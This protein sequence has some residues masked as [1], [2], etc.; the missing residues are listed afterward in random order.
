MHLACGKKYMYAH[1]SETFIQLTHVCACA[2]VRALRAT[3]TASYK[4]HNTHPFPFI[5]TARAHAYN[6]M[7][8][9]Q[10]K[11]FSPASTT[12]AHQSY[13]IFDTRCRLNKMEAI[14]Q[15]PQNLLVFFSFF[16]LSSCNRLYDK[17]LV[18]LPGHTFSCTSTWVLIYFGVVIRCR[19]HFKLGLHIMRGKR[20]FYSLWYCADSYGHSLLKI[21]GQSKINQSG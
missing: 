3:S 9:V 4:S 15:L 21:Q 11:K 6:T 1:K 13:D 12:L 10:C 8:Y 5:N 20:W 7:L 14:F 19:L 17:N 18:H 16:F 2:C